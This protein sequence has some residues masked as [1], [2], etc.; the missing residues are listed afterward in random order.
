MARVRDVELVGEEEFYR[1]LAAVIERAIE[2]AEDGLLDGAEIVRDEA[3][4]RAPRDQGDLAKS[5]RAELRD[6][7][8]GE[9]SA[10]VYVED[11]AF[12]GK[13]MELGTSRHRAQPFLR[14][15]LDNKQGAVLDA[16][17]DAV[18]PV[19][20]GAWDGGGGGSGGG[21]GRRGG[22]RAPAPGPAGGGPKGGPKSGPKSPPA[23]R[24]RA[25]AAPK[26][27]PAPAPRRR[28]RR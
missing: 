7:S 25:P 26:R 19:L 10:A 28:G 11:D 3:E 24:G 17:R 8:G 15:A 12:W 4:R 18:A 1:D 13:Y 21:G 20:D 22:S 27:R 2:A 23:P 16:I 5:I 9:I 14:P 6:T